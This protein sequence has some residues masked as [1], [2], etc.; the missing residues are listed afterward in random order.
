M[1]WR[2]KDKNPAYNRGWKAARLA[3]WVPKTYATRR[4]S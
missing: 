2:E 1:P 4:Y 3:L